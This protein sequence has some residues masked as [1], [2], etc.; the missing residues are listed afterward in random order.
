MLFIGCDSQDGAGIEVREVSQA[1]AP[2]IHATVQ[3]ETAEVLRYPVSSCGTPDPAVGGHEFG[4]A[5][6]S[7]IH[8]GL[9]RPAAYPDVGFE[10]D[11]AESFSVDD[12]GLRYTFRL[13]PGLEFADGSTLTAHDFVWSW[14]RAARKA[15]HGSSAYTVF[16]AVDGFNEVAGAPDAEMSGIRAVDDATLVVDLERPV[17]H[18]PM[19]LADPVAAV[20]SRDN[21]LYWDDVW[22]NADTEQLVRIDSD[23]MPTGAGTF[24]LVEYDF[25]SGSC[26]LE[27]NTRH[28]DK[29][30]EVIDRIELIATAPDITG[31]DA[32]FKIGE[33]DADL[34]RVKLRSDS[35][36]TADTLF[37]T[38]VLDVLAPLHPL[39]DDLGD[40]AIP[41]RLGFTEF[42]ILNPLVPPLDELDF[43][44]ALLHGSP[45]F[46]F[47][48]NAVSRLL[49]HSIAAGT[50]LPGRGVLDAELAADYLRR[51]ECVDEVD[52]KLQ[53]NSNLV[54]LGPRLLP[55]QEIFQ[56]WKDV[57]GIEVLERF[58]GLNEVLSDFASGEVG[59][60]A[61]AIKP[62]YP[63]PSAVLDR[64]LS[65]IP[66]LEESMPE[67]K[68]L[69][70]EAAGEGDAVRSASLYLE[71]EQAILDSGLVIPLMTFGT[72]YAQVKP[73]VHG[74]GPVWPGASFFRDVRIER[75]P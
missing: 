13:R 20:L 69:S 54:L 34:V 18:F 9:T 37:D 32:D 56:S 23:S 10:L 61:I 59:L 45:E 15:R 67:L 2:G 4:F 7:E 53:F 25:D 6:V 24:K 39:S 21:V 52:I 64:V 51:C 17:S 50:S 42:L 8:A 75:R 16:D 44:L 46:K 74:L 43:R 3:G 72:T 31:T 30:V 48:G 55:F 57:L 40:D 19:M 62:S 29:S 33:T 5:V 22:Y 60:R 12:S 14:N 70:D 41:T 68:A 26:V 47:E 35:W 38:G 73:W 71:L 66:G 11:L 1:V 63:H 65:E 49:P 58:D 36:E 27:R 28:W